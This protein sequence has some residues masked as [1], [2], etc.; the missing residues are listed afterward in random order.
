MTAK[1]IEGDLLDCDAQYIA[2]Q[3]NCTSKSSS[4]LA[5]AIFEKFPYADIYK[6]RYSEN[7]FWHKP[8][9]LYI[10]GEVNQRLVINMTSQVLPGGPGK[11]FEVAP[12]MSTQETTE[13]RE[14][15]F[16][17]CLKKI[18]AIPG[19]KSVAFPYKV[20][21][22]LAGGDWNRYHEVL[23]RFATQLDKSR[24]EVFIIK[25]PQDE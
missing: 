6:D 24:V 23:N 7:P 17:I 9:E 18:K 1:L 20:G 3:C 19:I 22:G 21:S 8:G 4:G 10:R 15:L 11:L 14:K 16:L 5:K 25:R 12:G 13:T 2:H